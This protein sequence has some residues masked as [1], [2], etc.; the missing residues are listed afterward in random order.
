MKKFILTAL[1][2]M[3]ALGAGAATLSPEE[4]LARLSSSRQKAPGIGVSPLELVASGEYEGTPTYYIFSNDKNAFILGA[5]DFSVPVI[6]YLDAPITAD[7]PMPSQLQWWLDN[8]GRQLKKAVDA[9]EGL[10]TV[11]PRTYSTKGAST[12][13]GR[14]IY[15][16][17]NSTKL[18]LSSSERT[19]IAPMISTRWDQSTPY[20]NLCPKGTYSGCVATAMAQVMNYHKYPEVGTGTVST[21]YNNNVLSLDLSQQPFD[22]DN[23][24]NNYRYGYTTAEGNAVAYLMQAC[25]YSVEMNYGSGGSGAQSYKVA[26]ALVNNFNYDAGIQY[27]MAQYY[28]PEEWSDMVYN[29]L[30]NGRPVL[31]A[32]SGNG[33]GHEFVCDGYATDGTFHFNWGWSGAYDGYFPLNGL[34]PEGQGIGGNDGSGFNEGQDALFGVQKPTGNSQKQEATL[35]AY[36]TRLSVTGSEDSREV[37]VSVVGGGFYNLTPY[38]GNFDIA[39]QLIS[40]AD[41]SAYIVDVRTSIL[42]PFTGYTALSNVIPTQVPDGTY[43][44]VPVYRVVGDEDWKK[45]MINCSTPTEITVT[46]GQNSIDANISIGG[47]EP[48]DALDFDDAGT[49]TGFYAGKEADLLV[50][51]TNIGTEV[52][53][54][55]L[56]LY[57]TNDKYEILSTGKPVKVALDPQETKEFTFACTINEGVRGNCYAALVDSDNT[58]VVRYQIKVTDPNALPDLTLESVKSDTG[59]KAGEACAVSA[60]IK[61]NS[62]ERID[63]YVSC[64]LCSLQDEELVQIA[65]IGNKVKAAVAADKIKVL[66]YSGTVPEDLEPGAYYLAFVTDEDQMIG[67]EPIQVEQGAGSGVEITI[68]DLTNDAELYDLQGRRVERSTALPGI[69]IVKT[70][71]KTLKVVLR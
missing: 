12:L 56:T 47:L 62:T 27:L 20:N 57:I 31:Y 2:S 59:F 68:A 61:N 8:Y 71:G 22:W 11:R 43:T 18:N 58:I 36:G 65:P 39:F 3:L 50:P 17:R 51:I 52:V 21:V 26:S 15:S 5:D 24:K 45:I 60:I 67:Y 25:G 16:P 14:K 35:M 44:L 70:D 66:R 23:M 64:Y 13:V 55:N 19:A 10:Q 1:A 6:G 37:T 54:V 32:G 34:N 33:G 69:Y 53:S 41:E 42:K 4:A 9:S 7:T 49:N 40:K 30:A 28:S 46:L 63:T 29:E 48:V 38:S